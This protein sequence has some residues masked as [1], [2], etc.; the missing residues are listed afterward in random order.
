MFNAAFIM[1]FL[2]NNRSSHQKIALQNKSF[3][4]FSKVLEKICDGVC[5]LVK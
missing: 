2:S 1:S 5:F 4:N 3:E